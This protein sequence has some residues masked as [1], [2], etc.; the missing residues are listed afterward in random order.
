MDGLD[1]QFLKLFHCTS[2]EPREVAN[3][4]VGSGGLQRSKNSQVTGV[5]AVRPRW[6]IGSFGHGEHTEL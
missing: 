3:V 4:I 6:E 1:T 5:D 2:V